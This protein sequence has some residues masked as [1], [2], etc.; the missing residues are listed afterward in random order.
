[1]RSVQKPWYE[2][3]KSAQKPGY[4]HVGSAQKLELRT[5]K[6]GYGQWERGTWVWDQHLIVHLVCSDDEDMIDH[7]PKKWMTEK[8]EDLL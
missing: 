1:M 4:Q 8:C 7:H 2:H 6:P 3:V 5:Q